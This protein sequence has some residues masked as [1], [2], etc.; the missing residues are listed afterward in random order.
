MSDITDGAR[1]L[2]TD[3]FF[4]RQL[5]GQVSAGQLKMIE[6]AG[7]LENWVP[8]FEARP[9]ELVFAGDVSGDMRFPDGH[10]IITSPVVWVDWRWRWI[11]TENSLYRL[12]DPR[13]REDDNADE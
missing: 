5:I 4:N 8:S 7:I 11:R 13:Y 6:A 1:P 10:P 3:R 9:Q 12:G 2:L